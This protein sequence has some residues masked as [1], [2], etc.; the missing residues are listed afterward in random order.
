MNH[1][2]T[3]GAPERTR[4]GAGED[5]NELSAAVLTATNP[6]GRARKA[7]PGKALRRDG[8]DSPHPRASTK[9]PRCRADPRRIPTAMQGHGCHLLHAIGSR[10][11]VSG[12]SKQPTDHTASNLHPPSS[13]YELPVCV[14]WREETW[15]EWRPY[16][17]RPGGWRPYLPLPPCLSPLRSRL[18]FLFF[19]R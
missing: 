4:D 19:L 9:I 11:G 7:R 13:N 5:E 6:V 17:R 2:V 15:A 14:C 3:K 1:W 10:T 16:P 8:P 12:P 18:S